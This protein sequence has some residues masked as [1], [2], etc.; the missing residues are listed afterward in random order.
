MAFSISYLGDVSFPPIFFTKVNSYI[1]IQLFSFGTVCILSW[2]P[3]RVLL[4]LFLFAYSIDYSS[5]G[6]DKCMVICFPM[7]YHTEMQETTVWFLGQ[8]IPWRRDRPPTPVFLGFPGDSDGKES[9]CSAGHL[10]LIPVLGR[11]PWRRAW[12]LNPVF[13]PLNPH[14]QRSPAGYSP[15]SLKELDMTEPLN[16]A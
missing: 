1:V 3:P 12:Q 14:G 16:T 7:Q 5:M 6:F 9:A 13:L 4:D 8:K 11:F 15:W 2:D 10:G